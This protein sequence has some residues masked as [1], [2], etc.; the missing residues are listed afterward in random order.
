LEDAPFKLR[1]S[2]AAMVSGLVSHAETHRVQLRVRI[3][4]D[5]P[6]QLTAD[7]PRLMQALRNIAEAAMATLVAEAT[8]DSGAEATSGGGGPAKI[9]RNAELSLTIAP[10]YTSESLI[11][12]A[13]SVELRGGTRA[14]TMPASSTMQ[15][16]LAR[17]IVR[18]LGEGGAGK[19]EHE[20]R[21]TGAHWQFTAAMPFDNTRTTPARPTIVS[22]TSL[23]VLIVSSDIE[24]RKQLAE[25]TKSWRMLPRE[26]DNAAV[27]LQLLERMARDGAPI[28]LVITSNRLRTQDGFLLSFRIK[29]HPA[30]KQ[31]AIILLA[32]EGRPGDAIACREN[33]ISAYLR[34]PIAAQQLNE[35]ITAILDMQ[36]DAEA[37]ATLITRHSLREQKKAAVLIIDAARDNAMFAAA[38]LKKRDYRVVMVSNASEAL[39]AMV[40][41]TFDVIIVDPSDAGFSANV[42]ETLRAAVGEARAQPRVLFAGESPLAS[43]S[44]YDGMVLKPFAKDSLVNAVSSIVGAN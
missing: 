4:Q 5:V 10:E 15:I 24:E 11:H 25:V 23:P 8:N 38:G 21:K 3:E 12:L 27:A 35:A 6:E 26:A 28:P 16:A 37:T 36:D 2:V 39:E 29:H 41:E 14:R 20:E 32:N 44:A 34:Q 1:E 7:G 13:F 40:Q 30:L 9:E 31:T 42:V 19:L 18:A 17:Q 43:G 22:L 33:G